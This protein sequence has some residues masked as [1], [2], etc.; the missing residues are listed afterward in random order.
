MSVVFFVFLF[1]LL[2]T[3]CVRFDR[4]IVM[5]LIIATHLSCLKMPSIFIYK[6]VNQ[7]VGNVIALFHFVRPLIICVELLCVVYSMVD[8]LYISVIIAISIF[9]VDMEII[10]IGLEKCGAFC[11]LCGVVCYV[12]V[13]G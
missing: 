11:V 5:Y 12:V 9:W 8:F 10:S 13:F 4:S 7:I 2:F 3:L 1:G 6:C